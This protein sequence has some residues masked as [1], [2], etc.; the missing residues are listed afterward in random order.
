[1]VLSLLIELDKL[2]ISFSNR[3]SNNAATAIANRL[4]IKLFTSIINSPPH[5]GY[6]RVSD[7]F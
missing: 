2:L 3:I 5:N 6:M 4:L 1:M 7:G